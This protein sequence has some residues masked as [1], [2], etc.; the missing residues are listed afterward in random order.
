VICVC[1]HVQGSFLQLPMGVSG[2]TGAQANA[3]ANGLNPG[4][5]PGLGGQTA[6]A[7]RPTTAGGMHP[8]AAARDA[9]PRRARMSTQGMAPA[10][11]AGY[12]SD[13]QPRQI[14]T[15]GDPFDHGEQVARQNGITTGDCAQLVD[16][17]GVNIAEQMLSLSP[18]EL[19]ALGPFCTISNIHQNAGK[20]CVPAQFTRFASDDSEGITE[21]YSTVRG[22][23]SDFKVVSLGSA[24][25]TAH[26]AIVCLTVFLKIAMCVARA[27]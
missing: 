21:R 8:P 22:N 24:C 11:D 19:R 16:W 7:E 3:A 2:L 20:A 10:N 9:P 1:A 25:P 17:Y 23:S 27:H 6:A 13:W 12:R 26:A 14:D 15:T 5:I 18:I 4:G